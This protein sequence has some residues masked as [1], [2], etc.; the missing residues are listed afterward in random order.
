MVVI[1]R[2]RQPFIVSSE[3]LTATETK[4]LMRYTDLK[5]IYL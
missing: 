3:V 1:I 4:V 2:K 5:S